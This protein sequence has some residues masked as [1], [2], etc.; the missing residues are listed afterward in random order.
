MRQE[1]TRPAGN[2]E[3]MNIISFI[4]KNAGGDWSH[5]T[6]ISPGCFCAG[7]IDFVKLFASKSPSWTSVCVEQFSEDRIG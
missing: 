6:G 4:N 5:G 2:N 3:N 1:P 7:K